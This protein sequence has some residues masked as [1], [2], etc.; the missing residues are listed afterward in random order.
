MSD[1]I[2][3][4]EEP[5]AAK[6]KYGIL[7]GTVKKSGVGVVRDLIVYKN[8]N[9]EIVTASGQSTVT[10]GVFS[11]DVPGGTND[12][13]RIICLGESGENSEIY[14]DMSAF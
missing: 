6:L 5:L 14:E 4:Y 3:V 8:G 2:I 9:Q 13:F 10:T 12:R 1:C 7:S 11:I